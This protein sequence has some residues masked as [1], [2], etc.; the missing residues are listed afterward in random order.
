MSLYILLSLFSGSCQ[1]FNL[2]K[3]IIKES[4]YIDKW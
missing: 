4:Y 3:K 1:L 2:R